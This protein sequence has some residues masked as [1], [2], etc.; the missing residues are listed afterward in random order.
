ML[1]NLKKTIH[2]VHTGFLDQIPGEQMLQDILA[3]ESDSRA[4]HGD[5]LI[6]DEY[7]DALS[8]AAKLTSSNE[9]TY[10]VWTVEMSFHRWCEFEPQQAKRPESIH[11]L[12]ADRIELV[13]ALV[14]QNIYDKRQ[15]K[16]TPDDDAAVRAAISEAFHENLISFSD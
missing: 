9:A 8:Q 5:Q 11:K 3:K 14:R 1:T 6:F 12:I 15:Y 10:R 7:G 2:L 13:T 16:L 4:G